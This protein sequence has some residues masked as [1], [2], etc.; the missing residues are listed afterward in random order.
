V[1]SIRVGALSLRII[2]GDHEPAHVHVEGPGWEMR[3]RLM[4][5]EIPWDIEGEPTRQDVRRALAAIRLNL[6]ELRVMWNEVNDGP[7]R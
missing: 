2:P 6:P 1:P 7:R 3:V 5:P 4:A